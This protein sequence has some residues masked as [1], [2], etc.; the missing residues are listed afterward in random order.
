M[1]LI[2]GRISTCHDD[3]RRHSRAI[4]RTSGDRESGDAHR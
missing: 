2:A 4:R 3:A 1:K